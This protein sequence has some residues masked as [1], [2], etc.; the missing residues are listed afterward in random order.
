MSGA[1]RFGIV[2]A[3][4]IAV[5]HAEAIK[6][7]PRAELIAVCGSKPESAARLAATYAVKH[8]FT[9]LAELLRLREL[10]VVCI[11]LPSGLH[12]WAAVEAARAGKHMLCEKPL[13]ISLDKV[14]RIIEA[15]EQH[16]V[17]LG[18]VYQRRTMPEAIAARRA[19]QEHQLGRMVMGDAYLKYYRS[20]DY[21]RSASWRGT[22]ALDGGGAL[23]NQGVHGIDLMQWIMG[24][25]ASV[26]AYSA[27]LAR[28]IEV[29]DTA[30]AV[31]RYRSGAF[32][33]IQGATS[34][35]PAQA[36]RFELLGDQGS[37]IFGD[38]GIQLWHT[39][40]GTAAEIETSRPIAP[41]ADPGNLSYEGHAILV[42]DLIDAIC[43][44]REPMINGY[45]A[46]KAV[47]LIAAMYE[48]S[49]TGKEVDIR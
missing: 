6:A 2:G 49:T 15:V 5:M 48:S 41:G 18:C 26:F 45:E 34:V 21:Y 47:Q 16:N 38:D 40:S 11:C 22:W 1:L 9:E 28:D 37:I 36:T 31:V 44:D 46:R 20:P 32:G 19:V 42:E 43:Q 3:G 14:D 39:R 13:E 24:D 23:M 25:V 8:V 10:D 27:A 35:F 7:S 30:V 33:V 29:E 4:A 17:K 12:E